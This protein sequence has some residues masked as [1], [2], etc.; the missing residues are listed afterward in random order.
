[1][2]KAM[3]FL[4]F[5]GLAGSLWAD[6]PTAGRWKLNLAR[7]KL[8]AGRAENIEEMIVVFRELN[9]NTMEVTAT[10]TRK[11]STA[12]VSKWTVPKNGGFQ[13]YQQGGPEKGISIFKVMVDAHTMYNVYVQDGKQTLLMPV[14]Y[15]KDFRTYTIS[16]TGEDAQGKPSEF[17]V[18]YEKQ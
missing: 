4:A 9:A 14:T 6:D 8:P 7:S 10:E 15:S 13:T 5:W 11:D 12:S 1:M 2:R 18:F 17:H 16:W 3:L